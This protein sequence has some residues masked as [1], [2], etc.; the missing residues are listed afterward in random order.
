M[1]EWLGSRAINQKV[2]S[3]SSR[4]DVVSLGKALHP[5]CLWENDPV[6]TVSRSRVSAKWQNVM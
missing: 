2:V 4:A 3:I 1:A 6:L 5:T